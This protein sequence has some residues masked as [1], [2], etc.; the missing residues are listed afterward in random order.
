[1][2]VGRARGRATSKSDQI[3]EGG[4]LTN[5]AVKPARA[6][7]SPAARLPPL[8][9]PDP[10]ARATLAVEHRNGSPNTS[11]ALASAQPRHTRTRT[12]TRVPSTAAAPCHARPRRLSPTKGAVPRQ[13]PQ[14]SSAQAL[15][16]ASSPRRLR[17]PLLP[18]P[19]LPPAG[20]PANDERWT[21]R[22]RLASGVDGPVEQPPPALPLTKGEPP[23]KTKGD[24]KEAY[25][26]AEPGVCSR[27]DSSDDDERGVASPFSGR[28]LA[29]RAEAVLRKR[30]MPG[31]AGSRSWRATVDGVR[32]PSLVGRMAGRNRDGGG[33]AGT[34]RRGRCG[35]ASLEVPESASPSNGGLSPTNGVA[36]QERGGVG[37]ASHAEVD[38]DWGIARAETAVGGPVRLTPG[39]EV[40]LAGV[41]PA[42][43]RFLLRGQGR[44]AKRFSAR[45][46]S[47]A[48]ER[49][50]RREPDRI[51]G[52]AGGPAGG[53]RGAGSTFPRRRSERRVGSPGGR[54][55]FGRATELVT[56]TA[57]WDGRLL[58]V[59]GG[60]MGPGAAPKAAPRRPRDR[61]LVEAEEEAST[62]RRERRRRSV[63]PGS[64]APG[65]AAVGCHSQTSGSGRCAPSVVVVLAGRRRHSSRVKRAS[66]AV[67]SWNVRP[68]QSS[69]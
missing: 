47:D 46:D 26:H 64:Y 51:T 52:S 45:S 32:S 17:S 36:G 65:V 10:T 53:G 38:D 14:S 29:P 3:S 63:A 59:R 41:G 25:E 56:A 13:N 54:A 35:E 57:D 4:R 24:E 5:A 15:S 1:M 7:P 12:Y 43:A 50:G 22:G 16:T 9:W 20:L 28:T 42:M 11:S 19:V 6:G 67:A 39:A 18:T 30:A 58:D 61:V 68:G 8:C 40:S 69:S 34:T 49:R 60:Q 33:V 62:F 23:A 31:V 21:R 66:A 2:R 27:D 44:P 48:L 55:G 37:C